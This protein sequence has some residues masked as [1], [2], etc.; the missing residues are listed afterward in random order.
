[1][2]VL[3]FI[4]GGILI[5]L[6]GYLKGSLDSWLFKGLEDSLKEYLDKRVK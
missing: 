1:M 5:F 6:A 2:D 4:G 3:V